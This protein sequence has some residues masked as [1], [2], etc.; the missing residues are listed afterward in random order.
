MAVLFPIHWALAD[1]SDRRR[2]PHHLIVGVCAA[3]LGALVIL[4]VNWYYVF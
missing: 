3:G 1:L 2:I 4:F